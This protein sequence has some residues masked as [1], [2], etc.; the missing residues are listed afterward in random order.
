MRY[1][2]SG[3]GPERFESLV[4][5]LALGVFGPGLEPVGGSGD[6]GRDAVFRGATSYPAPGPDA[7]AGYI[8]L[9]AKFRV[10]QTAMSDGRWLSRQLTQELAGWAQRGSEGVELPDYLIVATNVKLTPNRGGGKELVDSKFRELV[11]GFR[12]PFK[13]WAVWDRKKIECLLDDNSD[14]RQAVEGFTTPGDV[15]AKLGRALDGASLTRAEPRPPLAPPTQLPRELHTLIGRAPEVTRCVELL[16]G[17]GGRGPEGAAPCVVIT[18][19]PGIGKTHLALHIAR[20]LRDEHAGRQVRLDARSTRLAG[21]SL[22][23]GALR[24]FDPTALIPG[25]NPSQRAARLQAFLGGERPLIL[26]D[27]LADEHQLRE[28]LALE[29]G[30]TV[31]ATSRA[32]LSGL[33][34]DVEYVDLSPLSAAEGADLIKGIVPSGRLSAEEIDALAQI[35]A[36]HPLAL[37]IASKRIARRPMASVGGYLH[38]LADPASG[39]EALQIG[40]TSLGPLLQL[41]YSELSSAQQDLLRALGALPLIMITPDLV[42]AVTA[43]S[44][45]EVTAA[46]RSAAQRQLDDL[47][48]LNLVEQVGEDRFVM[49]EILHRFAR[50]KSADLDDTARIECV[51]NACLVYAQRAHRA[52]SSITTT[53]S[54]D[55]RRRNAQAL[56]DLD[57]DVPG[58]VSVLE[59][60][61]ELELWN[62]VIATTN[63]LAP[64]LMHRCQ[65]A[66]LSRLQHLVG[67]AGERTDNLAWQAS[68]ALNSGGALSREGKTSQALEAIGRAS[69]LALQS[70]DPELMALALMNRATVELNLG[71]LAQALPML[72]CLA[73][74]WRSFGNDRALAVVLGNLA[75]A[76]AMKGEYT[77]A[78]QYVA[79]AR[80]VARRAGITEHLAD[81]GASVEWHIAAVQG[82]G[83]LQ[84]MAARRIETAHAI[85]DLDAE[86]TA[87]GEYAQHELLEGRTD[88]DVESAITRALEIFRSS[89]D[90]RGISHA[91]TQQGFLHSHRGEIEQAQERFIEAGELAEQI[92]DVEQLSRIY[93][94]LASIYGDNGE[95]RDAQEL[96]AMALELART[97]K[98][99]RLRAFALKRQA[100]RLLVQH[101]YP[102]AL[103]VS[104]QALQ[105]AARTQDD[106]LHAEI[107]VIHAEALLKTGAWQKAA[108]LLEQELENPHGER[109]Q[110]LNVRRVLGNLYAERGL[111]A[112]AENHL[113]A[114]TDITP[115]SGEREMWVSSL[116]A[117]GNLAMRRDD[118]VKA[119]EL[120]TRA[121]EGARLLRSNR[122]LGSAMTLATSCAL[123]DEH[124]DTAIE[125]ARETL[126]LTAQLGQPSLQA[127][128]LFDIATR[129]EHEGRLEE[130]LADAAAASALAQQTGNFPLRGTVA[131]KLARINYGLG[132][133]D[134]AVRSAVAAAREFERGREHRG[135]A[136]ALLTAAGWKQIRQEHLLG[137]VGSSG[138]GTAVQD[139]AA[140]LVEQAV[141]P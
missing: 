26:V 113:R 103:A 67:Q 86:A 33:A 72:R 1:D 81:A 91:L 56:R 50:L 11:E 19:A 136:V 18:G 42:A 83:D 104:T 30:H 16:G 51:T 133:L 68:A 15:L 112:E 70:E 139:M 58:A 108:S 99:G 92:G 105:L 114:V 120:A 102:Q 127:K 93:L 29:G 100:E 64:G 84:A 90:S 76:H 135:A 128:V 43:A 10:E 97:S 35:C 14:A 78:R 21:E 44:F 130:A 36:G 88:S 23:D 20:I 123:H 85:G 75:K 69:E 140:A 59:M 5:T 134:E 6:G 53:P 62:I 117:Y 47:V 40:D 63:L 116:L 95:Q 79:N 111:Y 87:L 31:I 94:Q 37:Q 54:P 9:Q 41:S 138:C 52:I 8:V 106:A 129:L 3:L 77:R 65:W 24:S 49:H 110:R 32:K 137:F 22:V 132:H 48:E 98:N 46:S 61:H 121:T 7:W 13:G 131:L 89:G 17:S 34:G 45:D 124:D 74:A 60:A 66:V 119:K 2:L 27:D 107:R 82:V 115:T 96:T 4:Q 12:L 122:M 25:E 118:W 125:Q 55:Q 109:R 80:D 141:G 57:D 126:R 28:L 73:N 38:E 101:H 39:I 71:N